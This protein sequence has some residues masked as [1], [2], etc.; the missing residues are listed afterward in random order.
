M[1]SRTAETQ[2]TGK[3]IVK[4]STTI[5]R[6]QF[7]EFARP[8]LGLPVSRAWRGH[9]SAL[10]LEFGRLRHLPA[11]RTAKGRHK[12]THRKGEAG[13]MIEWSWRV[14][15]A[16][17]IEVGSWSTE[18]R[19]D[20]GIS[21]LIG[22][23]VADVSVTGRLPELL[24]GLS[25]GRW[26]HSFMTAEGQPSW[27]VFLP[28]GSWLTVERGMLIHDDRTRQPQRGQRALSLTSR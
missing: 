20:A 22:P 17:S 19:L 26:V 2:V 9:G 10:F 25:D 23:R 3:S 8:I 7:T 24:V 5:T 1:R 13:A 28:D 18:Q 21:R 12:P 4:R 6:A 16:R 15:R 27:T 11:V 14:E